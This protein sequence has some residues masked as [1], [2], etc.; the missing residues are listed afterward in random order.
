MILLKPRIKKSN[1][2]NEKKYD[3]YNEKKYDRYNEKKYDEWSAAA[4][5]QNTKSCLC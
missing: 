5:M 1:R 2:Y 4:D 3:S